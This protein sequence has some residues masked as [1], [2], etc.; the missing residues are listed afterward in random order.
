MPL[1]KVATVNEIPEGGSKCVKVNGVPVSIW[2]IGGKL[3]AIADTCPHAGGPLSEGFIDEELVVT[4]P[5]HGWKFCVTD[6]KSPVVPSMSVPVYNVKV[7]GEDVLVE[8]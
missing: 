6:G 4:C 3:H 2:N 8:V 5:W 7:E 1:V